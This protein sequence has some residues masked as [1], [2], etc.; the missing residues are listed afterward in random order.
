MTNLDDVT[1][2]LAEIQDRLLALA[3]DART[4][5]FELLKERD[6]LRDLAAE[7]RVD[8]DAQRTDADLLSE[9]AAL[10]SRLTAVE[11]NRIDMVQQSGSSAESGYGAAESLGGVEL[12]QQADIAQG[13]P[14]IRSRIGRVKGVLADRGVEVPKS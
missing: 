12:N 11:R 4:E 13:L 1:R 7:F 8:Y 5:R 14:E 2:R 9:L 3:D 6:R 10:R